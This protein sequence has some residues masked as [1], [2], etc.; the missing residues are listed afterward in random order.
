MHR[1]I[2]RDGE[3]FWFQTRQSALDFLRAS[4]PDCCTPDTSDST[5]LTALVS[6]GDVISLGKL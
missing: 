6:G 1:L 2:L 5:L 3:T 4:F